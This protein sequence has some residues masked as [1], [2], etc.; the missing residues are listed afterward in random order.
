MLRVGSVPYLVARPLDL[1]LGDEEGIELEYATPS[2]LVDRLR[3]GGLDVALVSSIELFRRPGYG[4]LDG[5][6]IA[7]SGFVSSVQVFLRRPIE[8]VEK[9]ALDPASRTAA[10]LTRVVWPRTS[11]PGFLEVSA[12]SDPCR[13]PA[14]A[15]LRIGDA[16]LREYAALGE[17]TVFNPSL[18]WNRATGLPFV[19][20]LWTARPG[21][22]L[23]PHLP[24]FLRSRE[25]GAAALEELAR[26]ASAEWSLSPSLTRHYL[27]EEC[28]FEVGASLLPALLEF[29]DRAARLGLARSDL[30][31]RAIPA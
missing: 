26:R 10:A 3:E 2:V 27:C 18:A 16:A 29:R 9:V 12:G 13:A 6:V 23:E 22:E 19:F 4:Y 24:A 28:R 25:R 1:G 8:E 31:P 21:V 11:L 5:G 17:P 14:D 7:G 15:W 20:A 30:E